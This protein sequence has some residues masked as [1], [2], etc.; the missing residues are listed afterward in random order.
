MHMPQVEALIAGVVMEADAILDS[1]MP[2][3]G[4]MSNLERRQGVAAQAAVAASVLCQKKVVEVAGEAKEAREAL[5]MAE[6]EAS[7]RHDAREEARK[8][9]R[10]A[11]LDARAAVRDSRYGKGVTMLSGPITLRQTSLREAFSPMMA[12]AA[13]ATETAAVAAV[14]TE[15][16]AVAKLA[17]TERAL[18]AARVTVEVKSVTLGKLIRLQDE[19]Q[20]RSDRQ[21]EYASVKAMEFQFKLQRM[22]QHDGCEQAD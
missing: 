15:T 18:T 6:V 22:L 17:S 9:A 10:A 7:A 11:A 16:A 1:Q 14:A 20:Q 12:A 2:H 19:A 21:A 4:A 5:Q 3:Q 13:V 8:E